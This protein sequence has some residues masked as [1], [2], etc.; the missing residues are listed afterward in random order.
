[1]RWPASLLLSALFL[2]APVAAVTETLWIDSPDQCR[3]RALSQGAGQTL[4]F[5]P[6]WTMT[7]EIWQ[8]QMDYFSKD[9]R[10][11]SFDPRGQGQSSKPSHGYDSRRRARDIRA[12]LEQAQAGPAVLIGW[13]LGAVDVVNYLQQFG[14]QGLRA[15]VLIDNSVDRRY[16]SA[17]PAERLL[18]RLRR[19]PY[20]EVI[21]GFVPSMFQSAIPQA[22]LREI[23]RLSL[24]TPSFAARESLAKATTGEGLASGLGGSGL[25]TLYMVTPH[26]APEGARLKAVLGD[27]FHVEVFEHSGHALFIDEASHFNQSLSAFLQSLP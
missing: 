23:T 16:A 14:T 20:E 21:S 11:L 5:V 17:P 2:G 4:V 9:H 19:D 7:A 22:Q 24:L 1:M 10:V 26:F 8:G 6:G 25:P 15:V 12:V 3:L 13:S 27:S 18:E